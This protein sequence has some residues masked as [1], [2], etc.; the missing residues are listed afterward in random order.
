MPIALQTCLLYELAIIPTNSGIF[1]QTIAISSI[2][3]HIQQLSAKFSGTAFNIDDRKGIIRFDDSTKAAQAA[4]ELIGVSIQS[5]EGELAFRVS[6]STG[7]LDS[8]NPD[9]SSELFK[10]LYEINKVV[11]AGEA[12]MCQATYLVCNR[13]ILPW[14]PYKE[15][16]KSSLPAL[17]NLYKLVSSTQCH[18]HKDLSEVLRTQP[19]KVFIVSPS[20]NLEFTRQPDAKTHVIFTGYT[21]GSQDFN[22]VLNSL[23]TLLLST[24]IWYQSDK[25]TLDDRL[26]WLESGKKLIISSDEAMLEAVASAKLSGGKSSGSSTLMADDLVDVGDYMLD[27]V[28]VALPKVP[29]QGLIQSYSFDLLSDGSWGFEDDPADCFMKVDVQPHRVSVASYRM[30]VTV[31]GRRVLQQ[32]VDLRDGALIRTP[33]GTFRYLSFS[34]IYRG[35]IIGIQSNSQPLYHGDRFEIGREPNHPGLA[36]AVRGGEDRIGWMN[37][38]KAQRIKGSGWSWDRSWVGRRQTMLHIDDN[39]EVWVSPI[40]ERL[41][42]LLF[43]NGQLIQLSR[44][45]KAHSGDMI[46]VGTTVFSL[47]K[48]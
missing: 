5:Q 21:I 23:P 35:M 30:D 31:N 6:L 36:L 47:S 34:G 44:Q 16:N 33:L 1:E 22:L 12:A 20:V 26:S 41:P 13:D 8:Q 37:S 15:A 42:T 45:M 29:L 38:A 19:S 17:T 14:E 48:P 4:V 10:Q 28:G 27:T 2:E 43:K 39:N 9:L 32:P 18:I 24:N 46:I 25:V 7:Q 3:S 40:H 11:S